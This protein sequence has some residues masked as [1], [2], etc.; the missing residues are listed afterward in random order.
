MS[1]VRLQLSIQ[2]PSASEHTLLKSENVPF[3]VCVGTNYRFTLS[4]YSRINKGE[5]KNQELQERV[6]TADTTLSFAWK[7]FYTRK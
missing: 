3:S 5:K 1:I 7:K 2:T 6:K 4:K